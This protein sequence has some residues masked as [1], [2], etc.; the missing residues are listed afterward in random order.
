MTM[1]EY[2]KLRE[3]TGS[4]GVETLYGRVY[5]VLNNIIFFQ[6]KDVL[7]FSF[8]ESAKYQAESS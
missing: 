1:I 3:M 7:P 2:L 4:T 5:D 6:F 8:G